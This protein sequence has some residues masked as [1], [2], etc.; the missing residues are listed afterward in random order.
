MRRRHRALV[1]GAVLAILIIACTLFNLEGLRANYWAER[2]ASC[3]V[4]SFG[5][6]GLITSTDEAQ[7]GADCFTQAASR[8]RSVELRADVTNTDSGATYWF[9]VEA[10]LGPLGAC[11]IAAQWSAKSIHASS[12]GAAPCRAITRLTTGLRFRGCG[13]QGDITLPTTHGSYLE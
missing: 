7:R 10:P 1:V 6:G 9:L 3:G 5:V 2:A 12:S 11:E 13:A 8:C 4:L